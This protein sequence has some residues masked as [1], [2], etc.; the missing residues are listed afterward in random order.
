VAVGWGLVP[1]ALR[2]LLAGI[3]IRLPDLFALQFES[4]AQAFEEL[5][6]D[7][8]CQLPALQPAHLLSHPV[9]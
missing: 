6:S 1:G 4:V 8:G 5:L 3:W 9:G 2:F 7:S